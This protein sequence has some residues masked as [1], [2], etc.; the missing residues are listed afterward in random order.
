MTQFRILVWFEDWRED[1]E[2]K[3]RSLLPAEEKV[4]IGKTL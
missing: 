4:P 2:V 3:T 1:Q